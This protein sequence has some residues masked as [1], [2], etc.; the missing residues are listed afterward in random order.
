MTI[1]NYRPYPSLMIIRWPLRIN[2]RFY[3]TYIAVICKFV[4]SPYGQTVR[5]NTWMG[6]RGFQHLLGTGKW[7]L[8][9]GSLLQPRSTLHFHIVK[10]NL[11][12][13]CQAPSALLFFPLLSKFAIKK[14]PGKTNSYYNSS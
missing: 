5:A 13:I 7:Q 12:D 11:Q 3:S 9:F 4:C 6:F 14:K 1:K 10:A 2:H 8:I